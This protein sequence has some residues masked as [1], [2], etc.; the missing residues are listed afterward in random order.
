MGNH[1]VIYLPSFKS[2]KV[3]QAIYEYVLVAMGRCM[4]TQLTR[5]ENHRSLPLEL[6]KEYDLHLRTEHCRR[7]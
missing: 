6:F 7:T 2:F 3:I 4:A 1:R 5:P